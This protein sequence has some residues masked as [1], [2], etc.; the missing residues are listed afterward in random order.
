MEYDVAVIGGGPGGYSAALKAAKLGGKVV[1]FEYEQLGGTCL[2]VG[3]VPTKCYVSQAETIRSICEKTQKGIFKDAGRY[4]FKKIFEEKEDVV[5]R[6]T[7][8]VAGLLSAA[9]VEV[10]REKAAAGENRTICAG[11]K[12]YR[13]K[14]IILAEGSENFM[15]QIPGIDGE[16][17]VDSTGLLRREKLPESMIVIG[18]GVIGLEFASAFCALGCKVTALDVLPEL[19]INEDAR[20]AMVLKRE[21][22]KAG[23]QF[24]LGATVQKIAEKDGMKCVTYE[25]NGEKAELRGEIILV[26]VGR[27]PVNEAAKQFK[28]ELDEK[29]YAIVDGAMRTSVKN[30]YAVG[31]LAGGCLLAHAAYKEGETAAANCM[32]KNTQA[33]LNIMPRC[34]FTLPPMAA[35]GSTKEDESTISGMFPFSASGK[36]MAIGEETGFVKYTAD[37]KSKKLLGCTVIGADAPELIGSAVIA[38]QAGMTAG[39]FEHVIMPHPT[40][41]EC[42]KEAALACSGNALHLP[43]IKRDDHGKEI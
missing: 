31:D 27:K 39:A 29:G 2:N 16:N 24:L 15:P 40:L 12:T 36:A 4:S 9:G 5:K 11:G 42:M 41:G 21:L 35:V 43:K 18:A 7:G 14:N 30:I 25:R 19:L 6:L 32:G 20:A 34:I 8:G 38:L 13:A 28:V 37:K 3:C 10:V 33:K 23:V 17:V 1:L 22:E 26:A